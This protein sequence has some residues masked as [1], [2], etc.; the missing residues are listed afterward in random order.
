MSGT[1]GPEVEVAHLVGEDHTQGPDLA[2]EV[3]LGIAPTHVTEAD[4]GRGPGLAHVPGI[5][6]AVVHVKGPDHHQGKGI[7]LAQEMT[8]GTEADHELQFKMAALR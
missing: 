3:G 8:R 1:Q 7:G 2:Q 6:V 5:A 4:L